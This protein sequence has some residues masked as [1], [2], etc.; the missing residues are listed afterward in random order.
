MTELNQFLLSLQRLYLSSQ[1][2]SFDPCQLLFVVQ[3]R[4]EAGKTPPPSWWCS[5]QTVSSWW[6]QARNYYS[7][8]ESSSP[9][10][11]LTASLAGRARYPERWPTR[12]C[13]DQYCA[14]WREIF[15]TGWY[16]I[17]LY[18][19]LSAWPASQAYFSSYAKGSDRD[20]KDLSHP[21]SHDL[22]W[23]HLHHQLWLTWASSCC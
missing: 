16:S 2:S 8:S 20:V 11:H 9:H 22:S 3:Y 10:L 6:A 19:Q 21:S 1:R 13:F 5:C 14:V 18:A 12:A 17:E 15:H 4:H 23:R 7:P